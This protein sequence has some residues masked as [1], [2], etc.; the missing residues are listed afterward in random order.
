MVEVPLRL[1]QHT[2]EREGKAGAAWLA[3]LPRIVDELMT[4]WDC[5]PDGEAMHGGVGLVVPVRRTGGR[6]VIKVSFPHPGNVHEPDAF[7]AWRGQG[8]VLLY[9]RD[10]AHYAMLLERTH[11]TTLVEATTDEA[12]ATGSA[13]P[14]QVPDWAGSSPT[15]T[16]WRHWSDPRGSGGLPRGLPPRRTTR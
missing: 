2:V 15:R 10:D 14:G 16:T 9:E 6:A 4:R 13:A 5:A 8:A 12:A 1:E 11:S 7:A 3:A